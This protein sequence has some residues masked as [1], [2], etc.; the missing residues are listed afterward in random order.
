MPSNTLPT[1][2]SLVLLQNNNEGQ[3][4]LSPI[5]SKDIND[6]LN[7]SPSRKQL[8]NWCLILY[9]FCSG[10]ACTLVYSILIPIQ[11]DTGIPLSTLNAATGYFFLLLGWGGL[12]TQPLAL[13]FGKRGVYLLSMLGSIGCLIWNVHVKSSGDWIANKVIHGLFVS[14]IEMLVETSITD[15]FFAHERGLYIGIYG[16]VLFTSNFFAPL[17]GGVSVEKIL[18]TKQRISLIFLFLLDFLQFIYESHGYKFVF[19]MGILIQAVALVFCFFF[20]EEVSV[21]LFLLMKKISDFSP[22]LACVSD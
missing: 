16:L 19:Y 11:N 7:W 12:I 6:P 14:P 3:I 2:G 13:M 17:F 18:K 21:L 5:P 15:V 9:T 10:V 4:R 8:S 22:F 20:M 1:P